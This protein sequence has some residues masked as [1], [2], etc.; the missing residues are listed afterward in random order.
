VLAAQDPPSRVTWIPTEPVQGSLVQIVVS[1][2][3]DS[4][5]L[6]TG[7]LAGQPLHFERDVTGAARA[8][9]G[10]P[11]GARAS[12]PLMVSVSRPRV[13]TAQHETIRIPVRAG[14]FGVE[15]L[16][17]DPRF[18]ARPDSALAARIREEAAKSRRVSELSHRTPRLWTG[19][20][21]RPAAGRITSPYGKGREFNGEITSRHLG[22]DF[23]GSVG[24]PVVAVNRGVV[25]LIGDFF[26]SGN[27]VYL[28]HGRGLVT[29]YLHLSEVTVSPGDTVAPGQVIGRIGATGRVTGPHLH[30]IARYG[31]VSVNPLDLFEM[32]F[33][34]FASTEARTD[35]PARP[36]R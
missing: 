13:D 11:V 5:W 35:P 14:D 9:A 31:S 20:F 34:P 10:I 1:A 15:S 17:V 7:T 6:V 32:D 21:E 26:Y 27:V 12:I 33:T 3:V 2:P 19:R 18:T 22:T 29:A 24:D 28:D 23:N 4:G 16:Q 25:A 36:R 8:L 30:L